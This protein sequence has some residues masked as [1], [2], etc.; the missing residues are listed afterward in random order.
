M[1]KKKAMTLLEIMIVIFLIGLIGSVIGYS[2]KGSLDEGRVFKSERAIEQIT[3]ILELEVA[4]DDVSTADL[5]ANP[6]KYI[7]NSGMVKDPQKL[8]KDGWGTP[9]DITV[10]A[11]GEISVVSKK[12]EEFREA[13]KNKLAGQK[14]PKKGKT[15]G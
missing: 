15:S 14:T 1:K 13:K 4:K 11:D 5:T 3:D 10:D 7:K 9:F 6:A 2:M 8:L 12:L